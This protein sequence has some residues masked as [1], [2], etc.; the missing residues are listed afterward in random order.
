MPIQLDLKTDLA[1]VAPE[2]VGDIGDC[3]YS[4]PCAIGAMMSPE[5]R[6]TF[7][8]DN[9]FTLI[10]E[11]LLMGTISVPDDQADDFRELQ[12]QFDRSG[13]RPGRFWTVVNKLKEKYSAD[14][15]PA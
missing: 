4:A 9:D 14:T 5:Q 1:K 12:R 2:T 3:R 15:N 7:K 13:D 6:A 8:G 10:G 11:L